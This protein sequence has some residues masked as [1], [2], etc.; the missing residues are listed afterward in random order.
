MKS[1]GTAI[2]NY[3]QEQLDSL[4]QIDGEDEMTVYLSAVGKLGKN[5]M[6]LNQ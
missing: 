1:W 3:N 5:D 2:A 4:L 6:G